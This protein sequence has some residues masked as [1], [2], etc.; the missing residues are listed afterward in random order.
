[1]TNVNGWARRLTHP[2]GAIAVWVVL[3]GLYFASLIPASFP[4]WI[5]SALFP[6]AGCGSPVLHHAVKKLP[7]IISLES[8]LARVCKTA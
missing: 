8:A 5:E 1:M 2:G 4:K 3:I 7:S 6:Q